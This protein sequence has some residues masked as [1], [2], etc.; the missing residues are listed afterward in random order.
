MS[1]TAPYAAS[2]VALLPVITEPILENK[3]LNIHTAIASNDNSTTPLILTYWPGSEPRATTID[4][5]IL[6]S[7]SA[8]FTTSNGTVTAFSDAS[9]VNVVV[10]AENS[11]VIDPASDVTAIF[12]LTGMVL[13]IAPGEREFELETGCWSAEASTIVKWTAVCRFPPTKRW[14]HTVPPT[15]G[16]PASVRAKYDGHE[17]GKP[18]FIIEELTYLPKLLRSSPRKSTSTSP[19]STPT[20]PSRLFGKGKKRTAAAADAGGNGSDPSGP[21]P[22]RPRIEDETPTVPPPGPTDAAGEPSRVTPAPST[23]TPP[24]RVSKRR[25]T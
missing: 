13:L 4:D 19:S 18:I 15:I 21:S 23:P 7:G 14:E 12:F 25:A 22:K 24:K 1:T 9:F 5:T 6:V 17:G 20:T 8:R 11:G 3:R 10:A 2:I 16:S